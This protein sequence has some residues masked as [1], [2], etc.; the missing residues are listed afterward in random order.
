MN[1]GSPDFKV[2]VFL[3]Y[4]VISHTKMNL[5]WEAHNKLSTN[6]CVFLERLWKLFPSLHGWAT[7]LVKIVI[8]CPLLPGG[9][10]Q[11]WTQLFLLSLK[12]K[13]NK[14][15]HL[16]CPA[17]FRFSLVANMI[18]SSFISIVCKLLLWKQC[19]FFPIYRHQTIKLTMPFQTTPPSL[20]FRGEP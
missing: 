6:I 10:Q 11:L 4:F 18:L 16:I 9:L 13:P 8:S 17:F 15:K 2:L 20:K 5:L 3:L 12:T 19:F 14:T 1:P 7:V